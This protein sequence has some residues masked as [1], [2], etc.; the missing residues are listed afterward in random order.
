M[1]SLTI[2]S[3]TK[4][5]KGHRALDEVSLTID[6][7][8]FVSLLGPSGCGKTTLLRCI[9]GLET[10]TAGR[11][12]VAGEDITA[13]PPEKRQ[14][15][16]M[17]QSYALFPHMN[18]L[19]NVRF[20]LR[21]RGDES[22]SI[23][24]E[25]AAEALETVRMG[26]LAERMPSQLSGGQQQ[27]VALARAIAHQPRL[28]LLDEPLSNLDARLREDMQ[29]ELTTLHRDLG[30]TTVFVTHDQ[31]EA[32]TMSDRVVLMRDGSIEQIGTPIDIYSQPATRFAA[33]FL[34]AANMIEGTKR[35]NEVVFSDGSTVPAPDQATGPDGK[36]VVVVRQE[37][38]V[39][40][41]DGTQPLCRLDGLLKARAFRGATTISLLHVAGQEARAVEA[42]D[43]RNVPLGPVTVGWDNSKAMWFGES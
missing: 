1:S 12:V 26:H 23:Q 3:L 4:D 43:N 37:E 20:G 19:E 22:T 8:E 28:L 25:K 39:I 38:L 2:D 42:I 33:D 16:M 7:G 36:G 9:A 13:L 11:I 15:G 5:F 24:R 17:F 27:R 18:V 40:N 14:L 10:P 32:M 31:E 41:P 29:L 21:M 34:G 35:G 30:L 6:S